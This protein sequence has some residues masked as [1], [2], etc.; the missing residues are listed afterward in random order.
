[1]SRVIERIKNNQTSVES[2]DITLT[3]YDRTER[4]RGRQVTGLRRCRWFAFQH[5]P[6][7]PLGKKTT[8]KRK[9]EAVR[10]ERAQDNVHAR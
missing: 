7:I 1:M 8:K 3:P 6:D 9:E 4:I 10:L 2:L 5:Y